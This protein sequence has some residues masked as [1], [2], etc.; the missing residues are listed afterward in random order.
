MSAKHL[1]ELIDDQRTAVFE[2]Q[3]IVS[4]VTERLNSLTGEE[5]PDVAGQVQ[6]DI[7]YALEGAHRLMGAIAE[8][9]EALTNQVRALEKPTLK[10][11]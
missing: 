6:S 4:M 3:A 10:A 11:A 8:K 7:A 1:G 9:L 5:S 2:T